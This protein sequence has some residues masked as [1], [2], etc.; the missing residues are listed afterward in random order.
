[1]CLDL[2]TEKLLWEKIYEAGCDRMSI[3]PD[4]ELIFLPS[5]EGP[6]WY[7]VR[8]GDGEVLARITPNTGAH[9]TLVSPDGKEAY[10]AGLKS[11]LLTVADTRTHQVIRAVG[12][13]SASIRPFTVNGRQTLCFVNV[14]ELLGFEVGDLISG[15][16][17]FRVE[18]E[19]FAKGPTKRHGCPSHGIGLTPD[20]KELWLA[21]AF[22]S[23]MHIF[24]ATVM[25]PKQVASIEVRDQPGWITFSID[26]QYAYPSTGEVV[27]VHSRQIV[28][29]LKDETGRAVHSEKMMEIDFQRG[30]PVR[31]GDQFGFG[32]VNTPSEVAPV[33]IAQEQPRG[34]AASK[35]ELLAM[36]SQWK[37]DRYAD[38][39]PKVPDDIVRRMKSISI[40]EA[41]DFLRLQGY[42]NQFIGGWQMLHPDQPFVGRALTAAFLPSRPDLVEP[43]MKTGKKEGRIGPSNSWPIDML[44][45]GDVY[46]A[47]GFGKVADGT[48][49]GDNLGNAIY[50]RTGTGVVFDAGARD[51]DGLK[52]IEGFNAY[53]RGWDPSFL[54][55][56]V[57][58]SINRPIRI[59]PATV[60]PGDVILARREGVAIIPAHLAEQ[61]VVTAEIVA[62]KDEFGHARLKAGVYT[63]GQIDV[64]WTEP[65]K[66]DF[67]K[68]LESRPDKPPIPNALIEKHL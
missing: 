7:V 25:P 61:V 13:F 39:R 27:D 46:I 20:E 47:D 6:L 22:N 42:E 32:R 18:V 55:N 28:T 15:R 45:K 65:I 60:L 29:A 35:V 3:T 68:W 58:S 14:N 21:D 36:T 51:P 43:I 59:G 37:G 63:P 52:K 38:G 30:E 66:A 8:A 34:I 4:G 9:N 64:R 53:V 50:A 11:P 49:I 67:F 57:L 24:D 48:L 62:L 2:V 31:T 40:E 56:V 44:Q 54:K 12:P 23:R 10:L 1:M 5:F 17:Q 33:A 41:W 16:K 19:G 26:G